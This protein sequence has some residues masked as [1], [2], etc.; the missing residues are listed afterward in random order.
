M[1]VL[2]KKIL[3]LSRPYIIAEIGSNFNQDI[4]V[5][6]KLI[7]EA[8]RCGADAVKFQLFKAKN[9]YPKDKKMYK[10]FKSIEL[11]REMFKKFIKYSKKLKLDISAST[12]DLNSARFLNQLNVDFHKVASSEL[13]NIELIDFLSKSK[14]PIFLSTGMADLED[15]RKAINV[16]VKNKNF[17][18][19]VMQCGSLY[20]LHL[21]KCNLNTLNTFKNL[22][23]CKTG[24]S[25]HTLCDIAAITSVGLGA[26]VFE[27][28]ITLNKKLKGPDHFYAM[29]P[30]EFK[31]Y[32][33]NIKSAFKCLGTSKKDFLKEER[34]NSRREGLY[35]KNDMKKN[36][37][38]TMKNFVKK[39]PPLGLTETYLK[40]ILNRKLKKNVKKN[41][42]IFNNLFY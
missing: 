19:V 38:F 12:F 35:F 5:G 33:K 23:F 22:S 7:K 32:I 25:D 15:I 31:N 17:Q 36:Q 26:I 29:E 37:I 2:K 39:R 1:T 9:L 20:P 4:E 16:C 18:I 13:S 21:S 11:S 30:Q 10:I 24:F 14:K 34:L 27:K 41:H 3:K 8:K 6:Y 40:K 42:P 28:H